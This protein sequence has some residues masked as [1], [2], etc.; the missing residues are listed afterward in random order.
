[1]EKSCILVIDDD[2]IS[3]KV[4]VDLLRSLDYTTDAATSGEAAWKLLLQHPHRYTAIIVDRV[5]EG[6]D[7]LEL[8]RLLHQNSNLKNIPIIVQTGEADPEDFIAAV[9]AGA[10]DFI[11]KPIEKD[12]LMH[13]VKKAINNNL[14]KETN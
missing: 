12:L 13:V 6:I 3:L 2:P 5:M 10:S 8:I 11:Y 9:K 14:K 4:L 7:A 1:M